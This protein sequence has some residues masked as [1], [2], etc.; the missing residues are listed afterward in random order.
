VPPQPPT[1][2]R[3]PNVLQPRSRP[4]A[5]VPEP[6]DASVAFP[7]DDGVVAA[8]VEMFPPRSE[9]PSLLCDEFADEFSGQWIIVI[10][11]D[12]RRSSNR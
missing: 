10:V 11:S 4:Q 6:I 3:P 8:T 12:R 2:Q 1:R 9:F 5:V 7:E